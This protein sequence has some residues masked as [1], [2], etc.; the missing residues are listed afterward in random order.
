MSRDGLRVREISNEEGKR[1][2]G[3]V[4]RSSGSVGSRPLLVPGALRQAAHVTLDTY[5]NHPSGPWAEP[6]RCDRV[7]VPAPC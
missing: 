1:L 6:E 5:R 2:L 4:P 7:S 3:S